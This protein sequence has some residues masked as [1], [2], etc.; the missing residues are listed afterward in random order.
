MLVPQVGFASQTPGGN[1]LATPVDTTKLDLFLPYSGITITTEPTCWCG[2]N[3]T[4]AAIDPVTEITPVP[5]AGYTTIYPVALRTNLLLDIVG[6]VN[7]GVEVPLGQRFSIAGDFVYAYTRINN[8]FTLQTIQFSLEGRYWFNNKGNLLTGWNAG[9]YGTYCSRF[10]IQWGGGYQGDGYW[11]TGLSGGYSWRLTNRLN[12]DVSLM[13][14]V[15]Y[16]PEVRHYDKPQDGHLIWKE[17]RYDAVRFLPTQVRAN[18]V[19]FIGV[20]KKAKR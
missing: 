7:L 13:A 16:M 9:V 3:H 14:G 4:P 12:L 6:G 15:V 11:S 1:E 5:E 2:Q 20:K 10:D 8:R 17:T 18:L 19:W